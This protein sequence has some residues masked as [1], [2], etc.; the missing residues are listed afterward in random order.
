MQILIYF[1]ATN[2]VND[3]NIINAN[4]EVDSIENIDKIPNKF[5]NNIKRNDYFL[6]YVTGDTYE[7]RKQSND[8]EPI[9]NIG[10][11]KQKLT[12]KYFD[13][14]KYMIRTSSARPS[15]MSSK[16]NQNYSTMN[17]EIRVSIQKHNLSHWLVKGMSLSFIVMTNSTWFSHNIAVQNE[18]LELQVLSE[19][20][21]GY[22]IIEHGNYVGVSFHVCSKY[23]ETLI[24]LENFIRKKFEE[25]VIQ[26]LFY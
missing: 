23:K 14:G 8:W 7:F 4:N 15:S 21:K 12:E 18:K 20:G 1:L 5:L 6:D 25:Q 22:M 13:R 17:T 3:I 26:Y 9:L 10:L 19:S 16:I 2:F 11:H 24:L